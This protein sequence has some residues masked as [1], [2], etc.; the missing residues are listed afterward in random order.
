M[1]SF[2]FLKEIQEEFQHINCELVQLIKG[3]QDLLEN[4]KRL[5]VDDRDTALEG[6]LTRLSIKLNEYAKQARARETLSSALVSEEEQIKAKLAV[7][8]EEQV[9]LFLKFFLEIQHS[10]KMSDQCTCKAHA[11]MHCSLIGLLTGRN[12]WCSCKS[13]GLMVSNHSTLMTEVVFRTPSE[14]NSFNCPM[15]GERAIL[16]QRSMVTI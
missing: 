9:C 8:E 3:I 10:S 5:P 1:E 15:L 12:T 6:K 14:N 13:V 11:C 16:I 7:M 4:V 2:C